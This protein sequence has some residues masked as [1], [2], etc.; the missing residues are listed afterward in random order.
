MSERVK[1]ILRSLPKEWRPKKTA[2]K[3]SKNLNTL[4]LDNLIGSL[5]NYE[6]ELESERKEEEKS[7]RQMAFKS[8]VQTSDETEIDE[9]EA[10]MTRKFKK[11]W[12]NPSQRK[13]YND[14]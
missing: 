12:K 11:M 3:E 1:K 5:I 9:E 2:I 8:Q 7:K 13:I 10:M 4:S 6:E 14:F